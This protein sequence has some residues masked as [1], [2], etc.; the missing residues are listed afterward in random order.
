MQEPLSNP[1]F[2]TIAIGDIIFY[3]LSPEDLPTHPEKEWSGVVIA[4]HSVSQL[5]IVQL[6]TEGFE[7]EEDKVPFR[8]IIRVEKKDA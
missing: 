4:T 8:Q 6:L 3:H 7:G 1:D 2:S 5:A